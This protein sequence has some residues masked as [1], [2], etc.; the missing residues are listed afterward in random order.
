MTKSIIGLESS[1]IMPLVAITPLTQACYESI[2]DKFHNSMLLAH[3]DSIAELKN[4]FNFKANTFYSSPLKR[5]EKIKEL[6]LF[7][8]AS[9]KGAA[10]KLLLDG[11]SGGWIGNKNS[12]VQTFFFSDVIDHIDN[13]IKDPREFTEYLI[14]GMKGKIQTYNRMLTPVN[15]MIR[16]DLKQILPYWGF[17][18]VSPSLLSENK[19]VQ[20]A[21]LRN[22]ESFDMFKS[23]PTATR[24]DSYHYHMLKKEK[25][26]IILVGDAN[27]KNNIC[28][29]K[30]CL[31]YDCQV[32]V[33]T[34]SKRKALLNL[35]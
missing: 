3:E 18:N 30:K 14:N 27:Y 31:S 4:I 28:S 17:H 2:W 16:I 11:Q 35:I 33:L 15:G 24:R 26:S 9:L 20:I 22:C 21:I 23:E 34:D 19:K 32:H 8:K 25:V 29:C 12:R 6:L 10:I 1:S 7:N 5:L 13:R